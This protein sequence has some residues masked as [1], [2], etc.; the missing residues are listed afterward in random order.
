MK[1]IILICT[2][3]LCYNFVFSQQENELNDDSTNISGYVSPFFETTSAIKNLNYF[4]GSGGL[5]LNKHLIVGGFGKLLATNFKIDSLYNSN[6]S[7]FEKDLELNMGGGGILFGYK[8]MPTKKIQPIIMLW[9]G[10]GNLSVNKTVERNG[11]KWKKNIS[12]FY[13]DFFMLDVTFEINYT[14]IKFLS[15]GIGAHY[16]TYA[17]LTLTNYKKTDFDG[18][19]VYFNI[20][21]IAF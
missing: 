12:S 10:G 11:G 20:K 1:T 7:L 19:G 14:P 15:V 4:G 5:F 17:G 13:D 9:A 3:A 2:F 18:Y 8:F 21:I 6:D 16:L